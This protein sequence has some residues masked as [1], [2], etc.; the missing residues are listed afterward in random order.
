MTVTVLGIREA[1]KLLDGYQGRELANA[2]R[3]A[4]RAAANTFR[5][6]ISA[7][8]AARHG[9]G[10]GNVPASFTKVPA[11]KVTTHGGG[12][13][14]IE[15]YV[16]PKSPL[17]NILEPGAGGHTIAPRNGSALAGRPG[18]GGWSAA[19]R[20]RGPN[21]FFARGPVRHPGLAAR[22]IL[23]GAFA[24]GAGRAEAAAEAA[25]FGR[26]GAPLGSVR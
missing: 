12:G 19:G 21:G 3:R 1:E 18:E 10:G 5:P 14:G 11:A 8:A 23:P 9:S 15:A 7:A 6:E 16:R 13:R 22:P 26:P 25:I 17:F 4:V 2:E 24:A 20:K